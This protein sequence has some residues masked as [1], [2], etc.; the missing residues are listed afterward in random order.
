MGEKRKDR[1]QGQTE[2]LREWIIVNADEEGNFVYRPED[3]VQCGFKNPNSYNATL[4]YLTIQKFIKNTG[5]NKYQLVKKSQPVVPPPPA[6]APPSSPVAKARADFL[7]LSPKEDKAW[8]CFLDS[9]TPF[10]EGFRLIEGSYRAKCPLPDDDESNAFLQKMI[11]YGILSVVGQGTKGRIFTVIMDELHYWQKLVKIVPEIE[12]R[13]K[14]LLAQRQRLQ[15]QIDKLDRE[16]RA[17]EAITSMPKEEQAAL[18]DRI[19]NG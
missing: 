9:L 6:V 16:I 17:L 15:P 10:K 2:K 12:G 8:E 4:Y 3:F 11:R 13:L 5:R 14:D 1:R 7:F 18:L 19:L